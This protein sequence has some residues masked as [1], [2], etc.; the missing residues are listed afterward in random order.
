M[1]RTATLLAL[2]AVMLTL[3]AAGVDRAAAAT[4]QD[5]P[6]VLFILVDDLGR[7]DVSPYYPDT[8]YDT[9][10]VQQLAETGMKFTN[11]YASNPVCSPNRFSLMTGQYATRHD[12]T[13]YFCGKR[14]ARFRPAPFKCRMDVDQTTM[15]EAF[16]AA[17]YKTY[18][19][20]KWHLGPEPRH[21][22]KN[23]GFDINKGGWAGGA[24]SYQHRG[25]F[26]PY[27][28]PRLED[29]P[30]GEYLPYRLAEETQ[31][32]IRNHQD[33][34]FFAYLAFY[35]V[36]N[37]KLAPKP[38]IEKYR[39]KRERLGLEDADK[40]ERIEQ[41]WPNAGPRKAR[42]VQSH[43]VYAAMVEATDRSI[44]RVLDTLKE[45][46]EMDDTII[47][48][49]SD[50]GGLST[51]EGHNTSNRP[52]RGGKGW[53]YEGGL[54]VPMLVRWPGVTEP[55]SVNDTPLM[56]TDFYPT[57]LEAAGIEKRPGQHK[58]GRS[59]VSLLKQENSADLEKR[60]L[61]WHYPHYG[62]QGGPPG[63]A[64]RIGPWKLVERYEDGSV[65][66][67]NLD[68]DISE[69]NDL[70]DQYPDRVK[71]MRQKLHAWYQDVDAK[72]L[73]QKGNGPEPWRPDYK[74]SS[75]DK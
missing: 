31:K 18:F 35:E 6:N 26:S 75:T 4:D 5:R 74:Q 61:Y 71:R 34:P 37:P 2:A 43:P 49:T 56:S 27:H 47:V 40:F 24:P 51:S 28:N 66:L 21:W 16:K 33:K 30:K 63:G 10:H 8:F 60:P 64:I 65:E 69:S 59:F 11:A 52:L 12:A 17:G 46:G 58:D 50:H 54:R 7:Q 68:K 38:L 14:S 25:Y 70:A 19:A 15:A 9:P 3:I 72:F 73:R 42:V 62:N 41:V 39:K 67:Y 29:G 23:Q 53:I 22:P 55:G 32:F 36:H 1:M 45:T 13:N 48:F 57:L 44:G 20:G